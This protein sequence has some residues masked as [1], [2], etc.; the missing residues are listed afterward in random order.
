MSYLFHFVISF[1]LLQN[2]NWQ[3]CSKVAQLVEVG[4]EQFRALDVISHVDLLVLGVRAVVAR[5]HRQ[6]DDVLPR[7]LLQGQRN[8]NGPAW[9]R[10]MLR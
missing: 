10:Y 5:P 2:T 6:Q 1:K 3:D 9:L 4:A 7:G 8:R